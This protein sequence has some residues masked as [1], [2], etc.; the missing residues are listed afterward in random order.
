VGGGGG[1]GG[2]HRQQLERRAP[3]GAGGVAPLAEEVVEGEHAVETG[4]L[5]RPGDGQHPLRVGLERRQGQP[6]LHHR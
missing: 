2:R 1:R 4:V 6:H 3:F 5:R